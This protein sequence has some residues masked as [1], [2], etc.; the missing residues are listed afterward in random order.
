MSSKLCG[1]LA[2]KTKLTLNEGDYAQISYR[3][4]A[5]PVAIWQAVDGLVD[6]LIGF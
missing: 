4:V 1:E 5:G 2:S 6:H 3:T